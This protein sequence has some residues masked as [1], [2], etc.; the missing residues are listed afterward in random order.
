M[1]STAKID[2]LRH[3]PRQGFRGMRAHGLNRP[4]GTMNKLEAKYAEYLDQA[5]RDGVILWY[6]FEAIT[7]VISHG[8][9]G[10]A[11]GSRITI[12]F[13]VLTA[14][15]SLE[16]HDCKGFMES[17]Q[18]NAL[19]AAAELYPFRVLMVERRRV[20]D[21]GGWKFTEM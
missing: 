11:K 6:A 18:L 8:L 4:R 13:F 9:K 21:G 14:D 17:R 1:Q 12:D 15:G 16:A 3:P 5:K 7:L 19:K 10:G 2:E 20:K